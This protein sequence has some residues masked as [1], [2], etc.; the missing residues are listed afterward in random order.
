MRLGAEVFT[1]VVAV[2]AL[3]PIAVAVAY[4][5][6]RSRNRRS[7]ATGGLTP[8]SPRAR[9][10]QNALASVIDRVNDSNPALGRVVFTDRVQLSEST[11]APF[12]DPA[13]ALSFIWTV[14]PSQPA[15][16]PRSP[17][18]RGLPVRDQD[19]VVL[20]DFRREL[21][22]RG[23][24]AALAEGEGFYHHDPARVREAIAR[25]DN[26]QLQDA[27][28]GDAPVTAHLLE[29]LDEDATWTRYLAG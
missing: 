26:R 1:A 10:A 9:A 29:L 28:T 25:T 21:Q 16:Y 11:L 22:L 3:I 5:V 27:V 4:A 19:A 14:R 15:D 6:V 24:S 7:E 13:E 12:D 17:Q 18:F 2:S 23:S 8:V 20:L